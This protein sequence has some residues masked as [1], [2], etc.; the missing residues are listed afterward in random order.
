MQ[1]YGFGSRLPYLRS[2]LWTAARYEKRLGST[3]R[4]E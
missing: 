1:L 4:A 3:D 2:E